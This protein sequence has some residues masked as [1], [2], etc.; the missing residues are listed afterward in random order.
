MGWDNVRPALHVVGMFL[1]GAAALVLVGIGYNWRIARPIAAPETTAHAVGTTGMTSGDRPLV[2]N[3]S[4]SPE[5]SPVLA[6]IHANLQVFVGMIREHRAAAVAA[7]D[8]AFRVSRVLDQAAA[9][10]DGPRVIRRRLDGARRALQNGDVAQAVAAAREAAG[11]AALPLPIDLRLP[12]DLSP[13][14]DA[15]VLSNEG[16]RIGTVQSIDPDGGRLLVAAAGRMQ[17]LLGFLSVSR[18]Q[19]LAY[20]TRG[21]VFGNPN[22]RRPML[23]VLVDARSH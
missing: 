1:L 11:I 17:D 20:A 4:R 15:V 23:V 14:R 22:S 10:A 12:R 7:L 2:D 8:G 5:F 21:L 13:Y 16:T 18:T 3:G 9:G 19:T 6:G